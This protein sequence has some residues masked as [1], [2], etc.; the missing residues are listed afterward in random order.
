MKYSVFACILAYRFGHAITKVLPADIHRPG[1][2]G[3][4]MARGNLLEDLRKTGFGLGDVVGVHGFHGFHDDHPSWSR[5][6]PKNDKAYPAFVIDSLARQ[7]RLVEPNHRP[8]RHQPPA[9]RP[10]RGAAILA[11]SSGA[12]D[13]LMHA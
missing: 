3:P 4:S 10:P 1:F 6:E 13:N 2:P 8:R 9:L 7:T 12:T 11:S 5:Q